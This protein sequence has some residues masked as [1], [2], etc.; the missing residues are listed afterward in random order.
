MRELLILMALSVS[1]MACGQKEPVCQS[2]SKSFTGCCSSHGG[3]KSCATNQYYFTDGGALVCTDN[4]DS[5]SCT[6]P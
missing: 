4:T 2:S 5:P 6:G 1:L 3:P